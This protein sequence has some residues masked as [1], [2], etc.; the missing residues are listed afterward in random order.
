MLSALR[1]QFLGKDTLGG[2]NVFRVRGLPRAGTLQQPDYGLYELGVGADDYLLCVDAERGV[3]LRSEAR[4][5]EAPFMV[6]EMTEVEFDV[7]LPPETFVIELP[8]GEAFDDVSH[9][10]KAYWPHRSR[11]S[12][13]IFR[14]KRFSP[15]P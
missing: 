3:V 11:A 4:L 14:R 13:G 7:D 8:D 9:H 2:R 15:R 6:I 12:L 5:R 1:L 10:G